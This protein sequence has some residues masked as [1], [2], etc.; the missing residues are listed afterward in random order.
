MSTSQ[1]RPTD[2][3]FSQTTIKSTMSRGEFIPTLIE[4]IKRT[5]RYDRDW[6]PI[7]IAK[8]SN[9]G[10]W[11]SQDNRRLYIFRVL[12]VSGYVSTVPV[13]ILDKKI[14]IYIYCKITYLQTTDG[15]SFR[16]KFALKL[17]VHTRNNF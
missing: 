1:M 17:Q 15:P 6:V 14:I 12:E 2:L 8:D 9:N 4:N 16:F 7:E 3:L 11:Y 13:S 10:R 5:G